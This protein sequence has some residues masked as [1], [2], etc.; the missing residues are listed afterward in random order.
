[1]KTTPE[2]FSLCAIPASARTSVPL[3]S[4]SEA[5]NHPIPRTDPCRFPYGAPAGRAPGRGRREVFVTLRAI[6]GVR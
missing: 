4:R 6:G 2:V 3:M 5:V 1:M